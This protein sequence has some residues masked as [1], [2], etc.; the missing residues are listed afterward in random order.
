[1]NDFLSRRHKECKIS[2]IKN[3]DVGQIIVYDIST[4]IMN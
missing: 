1:M 4:D 2:L 3:S